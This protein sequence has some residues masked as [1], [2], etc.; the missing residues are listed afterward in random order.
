MNVK[1]LFPHK[2]ADEFRYIINELYTNNVIENK[3]NFEPSQFVYAI[4]VIPERKELAKNKLDTIMKKTKHWSGSTIF[5]E[6]C[7]LLSTK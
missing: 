2:A 5:C 7:I 4:S 3:I 1:E 6:T